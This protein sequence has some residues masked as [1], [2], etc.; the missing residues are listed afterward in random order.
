MVAETEI[1]QDLIVQ[2]LNKTHPKC[3]SLTGRHLLYIDKYNIKLSKLIKAILDGE[4]KKG[5][6]SDSMLLS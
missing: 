4:I 2:Y 5:E 6:V 3:I 1:K